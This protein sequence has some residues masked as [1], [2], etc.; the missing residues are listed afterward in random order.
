MKKK[1][2]NKSHTA[3]PS[4]MERDLGRGSKA[5][6]FAAG[7]GTR[8]KPLTDSMPKAM[9]PVGGKPLLWHTI[10][11]LKSVGFGEIIINVHH[12]A[13]QIID[14][15]QANNS[16]GIRI[17]FSDEREKL[18]DTGGGIKKASWFFDD[19][20]PFL[21][22]N[23]DILSNIDLRNLY[24][25]HTKSNSIA[26]LVVSRR[27]TSRYF[28]FDENNRLEGWINEKTGEIKSPVAR[29]NPINYRKLAFSGIHVVD[30]AIFHYM[31]DFPEKFSIVDFYLSL[32]NKE[33]ITG[34]EPENLSMIDVGK[35]ESLDDAD[36][37]LRLD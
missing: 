8:L 17:E 21:I 26:T 2:N 27:E 25:I 34:F 12:F 36:R 16:F 14:Y 20:K 35:L 7:L 29:L 22:H 31:T 6:I 4:L 32:C 5:L 1:Q 19:D 10:H 37:F 28:L 18:L 24:K 9:V 23:V 30:P 3:S 11:K 15:V 33:N 13:E